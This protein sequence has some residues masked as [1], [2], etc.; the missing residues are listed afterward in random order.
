M[1]I[2]FGQKTMKKQKKNKVTPLNRII[3]AMNN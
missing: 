3:Q 1:E 2:E